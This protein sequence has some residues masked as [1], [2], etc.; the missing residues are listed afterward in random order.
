MYK[1]LQNTGPKSLAAQFA[2]SRATLTPEDKREPAETIKPYLDEEGE[3]SF[4]VEEDMTD[5]T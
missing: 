2:R 3:F 4:E 5:L 1:H